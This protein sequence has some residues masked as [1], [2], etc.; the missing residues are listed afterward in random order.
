MKKIW[1]LVSVFMQIGFVN[2][3]Q[4][5]TFRPIIVFAKDIDKGGFIS[6]TDTSSTFKVAFG[7]NKSW[8]SNI[9]VAAVFE[10]EL[11]KHHAIGI[12]ANYV[13]TKMSVQGQFNA[14]N[15]FSITTDKSFGKYGVEYIYT[16]FYMR[17]KDTL[18]P[19]CKLSLIGGVYYLSNFNKNEGARFSTSSQGDTG[20]TFLSSNFSLNGTI[21]RKNGVM[22]SLGTRIAI[23]SRTKIERC[24]LACMYDYSPYNM[25]NF[26]TDMLVNLNGLYNDYIFKKSASGS[27]IKFL[28]SVPI[29]YDSHKK[30]HWL[31]DAFKDHY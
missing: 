11:T 2:A 19:K 16:P 1:C 20:T 27:Q 4:K 9:Q 26:R 6:T 25:Y 12:S 30:Q 21:V 24:S 31:K 8:L 15:T 18:A 28:L 17:N 3:Q 14:K 5:I 23:C 22:F 29:V 10:Y 7:N 13:S